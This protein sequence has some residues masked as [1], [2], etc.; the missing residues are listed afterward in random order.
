MRDDE[1]YIGY[2]PGVPI[3]IAHTLRRA[4]VSLVAVLLVVA[5]VAT[6]AQR[7]LPAATFDYWPATGGQRLADTAADTDPPC[8]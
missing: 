4:V 7:P 1:F 5:G 8:Q 6:M 3:G 2:Q